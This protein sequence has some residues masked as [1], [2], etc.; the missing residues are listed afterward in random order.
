MRFPFPCKPKLPSADALYPYLQ[1]MDE[2]RFYTN[3]GPLVNELEQKLA[4][5][6][7]CDKDELTTVS[8][9]MAGLEQGLTA[10]DLPEGSLIMMPSW[11]FIATAHAARYAGLEPFFVDVEQESWALT[12]EIAEAAMGKAPGKISCVMPVAPFGVIPDVAGWEEFSKRHNI[13]VFIDAAAMSPEH[14]TP[15]ENICW[16][17]SLHATKI[18]NCGEGGLI[19]WKN[20]EMI[21]KIRIQSNFGFT[22]EQVLGYGSNAKMSEYHAAVGLASLDVWEATKSNYMRIS[23]HY[24][25]C[26]SK[27]DGVSLLPGYGTERMNSFCNIAFD[28][29]DIEK[30]HA[31]GVQT[32]PWWRRGCHREPYFADVPHTDLSVSESL[33]DHSTGLP[34]YPDLTNDDIDYICDAVAKA[35]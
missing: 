27:I 29:L 25:D 28:N 17:V 11:T 12:P 24:Y 5:W 2:N 34:C 6:I 10:M 30:L 14:V 9:G 4:D 31:A 35:R 19:V 20:P 22:P 7:G 33:A 18:L 23:K 26:L 13:P 1:R 3:F 15:S 8:T 16:M 32:R 21:K